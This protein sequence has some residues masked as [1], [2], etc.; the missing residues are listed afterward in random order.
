MLAL[1]LFL[2]YA[3]EHRSR[4]CMHLFREIPRVHWATWFLSFHFGQKNQKCV[5]GR[6]CRAGR[7]L[8]C[9]SI[10]RKRINNCFLLPIKMI[11]YISQHRPNGLTYARFTCKH[12]VSY[13]V[14]EKKNNAK[15]YAT[16]VRV[17]YS[18]ESIRS[19]HA[20]MPTIRYTFTP[21]WPA[22]ASEQ[23][24]TDVCLCVCVWGWLCS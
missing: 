19:G 5:F 23:Q 12:F 21:P 13:D 18:T 16:C 3:A 10:S 6:V 14:T 17:L 7:F 20:H 11:K 24:Y 4:L 15:L 1:I 9:N 22:D 2:E 8:T